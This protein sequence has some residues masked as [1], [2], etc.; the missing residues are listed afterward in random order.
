MTFANMRTKGVRTLAAW[1]LGRG[2]DHFLVLDVS[3]Y[4]PNEMEYHQHLH[5]SEGHRP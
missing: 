1:C 2:C 3:G 5:R 4:T